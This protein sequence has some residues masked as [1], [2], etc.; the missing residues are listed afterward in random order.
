MPSLLRVV[1]ARA[2]VCTSL[3]CH[4]RVMASSRVR[5]PAVYIWKA[6]ATFCWKGVSEKSR[7]NRLRFRLAW[8]NT[9]KHKEIKAIRANLLFVHFVL[10][11]NNACTETQSEPFCRRHHPSHQRGE[12][13]FAA[14][15]PCRIAP[16]TVRRMCKG[17]QA[18]ARARF[19]FSNFR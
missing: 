9:Q 19:V 13:K 14:W 8:G 15:K 18:P 1:R 6:S 2:C 17:L 5:S 10:F 4:R 3:S 11:R 7:E 16:T 12:V